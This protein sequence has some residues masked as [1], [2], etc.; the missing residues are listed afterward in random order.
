M[1]LLLSALHLS[2]KRNPLRRKVSDR[3]ALYIS[4]TFGARSSRGFLPLSTTMGD[5]SFEDL[6]DDL[7]CMVLDKL[8]K[9]GLK[10]TFESL[11]ILA[12]FSCV[13]P[14]YARLVKE[15]AWES[16]CRKAAPEVCMQLAH[17][18]GSGDSPGGVGWGSF[19]KLL[20]WCP[21][22]NRF[23]SARN[24]E[25]IIYSEDQM[26]RFKG[27]LHQAE[28][29]VEDVEAINFFALCCKNHCGRKCHNDWVEEHMYRGFVAPVQ[30]WAE[31]RGFSLG[32]TAEEPTEEGSDEVEACRFCPS[33]LPVQKVPAGVFTPW[34]PE[35]L[36]SNNFLICG[37]GHIYGLLR[38]T[39]DE[40]S[41]ASYS[42]LRA[43]F[44][45][46]GYQ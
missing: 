36:F 35:Y 34:P 20:A 3:R 37:V 39:S 28:S 23:K 25:T 30:A 5:R 44:A 10:G 9:A 33:F 45:T 43:S 19:A 27:H 26:S 1:K 11:K 8:S 18:D 13:S 6:S 22:C 14:R 38:L 21:G 42:R 32:V 15:R 4:S 31:D 46:L 40:D 2:R 17:V 16:A 24:S 41:E 7:T 12:S 29:P